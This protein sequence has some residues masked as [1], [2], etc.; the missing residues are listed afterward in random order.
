MN[1]KYIF[2]TL[3]VFAACNGNREDSNATVDLKNYNSH[4][5]Y[6]CDYESI[7][8]AI[9][10][11]NSGLDTNLVEQVMSENLSVLF[12][13]HTNQIKSSVDFSVQLSGYKVNFR[14]E[15]VSSNTESYSSAPVFVDGSLLSEVQINHSPFKLREMELSIDFRDSEYYT[16][17]NKPN[18]FLVVSHP[19]NW[20]GRMTQFSI[21]QIIDVK[22]MCMVSFVSPL[23]DVASQVN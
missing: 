1:T 2:Y 4:E 21:F 16:V 9:L 17:I 18:L 14:Q 8:L 7:N 13:S 5:A 15:L 20:V 23:L 3:I 12:E 19:S 10:L 6:E 11:L 22:N